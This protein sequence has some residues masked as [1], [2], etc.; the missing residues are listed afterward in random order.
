MLNRQI[1]IYKHIPISFMLYFYV[2]KDVT[3]KFNANILCRSLYSL[4]LLNN[5]NNLVISLCYCILRHKHRNKR[6]PAN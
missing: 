5:E 2:K 6:I 3:R 1:N 4:I